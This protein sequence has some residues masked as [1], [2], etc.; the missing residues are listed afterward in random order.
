MVTFVPGFVS[1]AGR[2]ALQQTQTAERDAAEGHCRRST[3]AAVTAA[4]EAWR[5]A[6]PAPRATLLQVADHIDHIRKV[7]GIDHIGLGGDF[8]GMHERHRRGLEDVSSYP[9][10]F[11]ELLRRGYSEDDVQKIAEPQRAARDARRGEGVAQRLQKARVLS[12]ATIEMRSMAGEAGR[13][14]PRMPD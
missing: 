9:A 1:P 6:N 7:A 3:P 4:M 13:S 8:D 5:Q 2:A 10:L 14:Q 12:K 11:A